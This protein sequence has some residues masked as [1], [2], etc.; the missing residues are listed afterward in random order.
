MN[1]QPDI[2]ETAGNGHGKVAQAAA[3]VGE[4]LERASENLAERVAAAK[5]TLTE[6][7]TAIAARARQSARATN[8]YVHGH[9]WQAL[10]IAAVL[11]LL[12]GI[13]VKRRD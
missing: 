9:P 4:D 12:V 6:T 2:A 11:G 8:D 1:K 5:K 10:G 13:A 3:G 7:S